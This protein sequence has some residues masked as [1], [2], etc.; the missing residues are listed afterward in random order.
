M[1]R[2]LVSISLV[3]SAAGFAA[4]CTDDL[5]SVYVPASPTGL[6]YQLEPSGDP[7]RPLGV[8]LRW[9]ATTDGNVGSYN[10]YS[11]ATQTAS[12][13]HFGACREHGSSGTRPS[14][15]ASCG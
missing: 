10:V 15:R 13:G 11:R 8:I 9:T 12:F 1:G 6:S 2:A 7:L 5:T 14:R 4:G 3:M